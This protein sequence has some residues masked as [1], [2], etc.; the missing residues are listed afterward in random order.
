MNARSADLERAKF[1]WEQ[2]IQR[3]QNLQRSSNSPTELYQ[4]KSDVALCHQR[5]K[6]QCQYEEGRQK[7][8][9]L[10][11]KISSLRTTANGGQL[12]SLEAEIRPWSTD[13]RGYMFPVIDLYLE[14][15][16][17]HYDKAIGQLK[18]ILEEARKEQKARASQAGKK[19]GKSTSDRW[20][21]NKKQIFALL[22]QN[23]PPKEVAARLNLSPSQISRAKNQRAK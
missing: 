18:D 4:A 7:F 20:E 3:Q 5:Y 21:E 10:L 13:G 17:R 19:S 16:Q 12:D 2:A 23:I 15:Q 22:D 14:D 8:D 1:E 11:A 6:K 9:Q